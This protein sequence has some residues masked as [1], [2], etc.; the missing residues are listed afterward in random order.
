MR[1]WKRL[2]AA[3]A[4]LIC[5]MAAVGGTLAWSTGGDRATNVVTTG[6]V[7]IRMVQGGT[8]QTVEYDPEW[9]G[10]LPG[11]AAARSVFVENCGERAWIR[12]KARITICGAEGQPLS[13]ALPDG[14]PLVCCDWNEE[15][16]QAGEDGW[17]YCRAVAEKDAW[18]E[19][20]LTGA[21]WS[22]AMGNAYQDCTVR[23]DLLAQAV[24]TKHNDSGGALDA[25]GWPQ[26]MP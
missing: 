12:A 26:E 3:A 25:A 23:I 8:A 17:Y 6:A 19:P 11:S 7:E 21:Q 18:T 15:A 5:I 1:G 4:L 24:Q 10:M 9:R 13:A 14:T 20:L 22:A 2:C 16:W